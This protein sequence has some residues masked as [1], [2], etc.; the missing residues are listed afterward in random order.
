MTGRKKQADSVKVQLLFYYEPDQEQL[1]RLEQA[2]FGKSKKR[3]DRKKLGSLGLREKIWLSY[4][5]VMYMLLFLGAVYLVLDATG[6][7]QKAETSTETLSEA[8]QR[9]QRLK[10]VKAQ[11]KKNGVTDQR[12]LNDMAQRI[13]YPELYEALER[14]TGILT[15]KL[16]ETDDETEESEETEETGE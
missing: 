1:D 8:E 2:L 4:G 7:G 3:K 14:N 5:L 13:V 16:L 12:L 11:L 10:E 15:Q 9:K 6:I